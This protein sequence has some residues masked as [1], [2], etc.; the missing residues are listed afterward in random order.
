M[1]RKPESVPAIQAQ[2]LAAEAYQNL[3]VILLDLSP[4]KRDV[5]DGNT[6]VFYWSV[7]PF[8][9][10]DGVDTSQDAHHDV[11]TLRRDNAQNTSP[12]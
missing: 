4:T 11:A 12:D 6:H 9:H 7:G 10:R 8:L 1:G 5:H 2:D 3:K